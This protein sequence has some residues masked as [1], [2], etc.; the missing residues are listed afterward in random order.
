MQQQ[1]ERVKK[2]TPN[3]RH[4]DFAVL[5]RT[6]AQ[7]LPI[8]LQF[9]LKNIPYNVREQDNILH[10][11]ELEKL[12]GVLRVKLAAQ[13]GS[14]VRP[15]DA[16]LTM[17]AYFQWFDDRLSSRLEDC[18]GGAI[19]CFETIRGEAFLSIMP[20]AR[21]SRLVEVMLDVV[22]APSLF[23][24]LD[25]L[26]KSFKG[27]RG[28]I[29]SLE[30]VV[31]GGVPLGEVYELAASFR[32]RVDAFVETV[33]GALRQAREVHAGKE[34]DGVAL[35]TYFKAKGLQWHTVILTSCNQ[36]LIPFPYQID[37]AM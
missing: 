17:K 37:L 34:R 36:G 16:M 5:Y 35:A 2:R 10:N 4:S 27:L 30:D 12:L 29:G 13:N 1:I 3:L 25:I 14:T 21:N 31:E 7:S 18:F 19:G 23:K 26:A 15:H 6:N 28:M 11:E 20:K 8:Q 22:A 9:I 24:T 33:D 32:G